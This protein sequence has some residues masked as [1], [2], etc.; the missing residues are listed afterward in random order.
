MVALILGLLLCVGVRAGRSSA[1]VAVPAHRRQG[2]DLLD[3]PRASRW[4]TRALGRAPDDEAP[5]PAR[6]RRAA[7]PALGRVRPAG[8]PGTSATGTRRRLTASG[9]RTPRRFTWR[10]SRP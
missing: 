9:A 1:L 8:P 10:A 7:R 5:R 6:S 3:R 4:L 2:R